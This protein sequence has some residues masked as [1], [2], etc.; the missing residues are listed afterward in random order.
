M[1]LYRFEG[2]ANAY[3]RRKR[4]AMTR[5][6]RDVFD[7]SFAAF[8]HDRTGTWFSQPMTSDLADN[9]RWQ[10]AN[11]A[12]PSTLHPLGESEGAMLADSFAYAL[13]N[14]Y[15]ITDAS[16]EPTPSWWRRLLR[17]LGM[18]CPPPMVI[19]ILHFSEPANDGAPAMCYVFYAQVRSRA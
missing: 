2:Q 3:A 19:R 9:L 17:A 10:L 12:S 6:E 1:P 8:R 13:E 14:N 5:L 16:T 7:A 11:Q 18:A 4:P 15:P